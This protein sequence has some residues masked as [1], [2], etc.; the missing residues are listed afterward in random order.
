VF[1][2]PWLGLD[3]DS[4]Y[5]MIDPERQLG[6]IAGSDVL[7]LAAGGGQQSVAFALLGAC[8][9]V[10]DLSEAQLEQDRLAAAQY[11]LTIT[12]HQGDMRNLAALDAARFDIVY[13]PYSLGFVP[14]ARVVFRQVARVIRLA[15]RY[16]VTC[17]NPFG[18]GLSEHDWNGE[19]YTLRHPYING[20]ELYYEDP[21]WAY[22]RRQTDQQIPQVREYRH[23]L[24]ALVSGLV[25][26]GFLIQ[27]ISDYTDFT[28]D[29]EAEPG[30]C[31]HLTALMPPWLSF[32]TVFRPDLQSKAR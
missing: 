26:Q 20:A 14:D 19:G 3:G 13:H 4:A 29:P 15:G 9:T 24:S 18:L 23:T 28:P 21:A 11:G 27:H 7:C 6:T 5:Q 10:V 25:E 2:R 17:G 32:W 16:Y 31:R 8:V 1:T 22:D 12:L 30:T